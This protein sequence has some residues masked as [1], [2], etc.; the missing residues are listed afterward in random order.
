VTVT[1]LQPGATDTNF[2]ERADMMT[3]KVAHGKKDDPAEVAKAGF[4]AMIAGKESVVAASLVSSRIPE[5]DREGS[6]IAA[7]APVRVWL[8]RG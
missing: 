3:T 8:D 1:A 7:E 4:A 5:H 2:F 6:V